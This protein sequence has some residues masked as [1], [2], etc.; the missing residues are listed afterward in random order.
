M[1]EGFE[2][3]NDQD[4]AWLNELELR[5][6]NL[7]NELFDW[8]EARARELA[9]TSYGRDGNRARP[10]TADREC[11]GPSLGGPSLGGHSLGGHS[12][13][14]HSLGEH[15]LGR[16]AWASAAAAGTAV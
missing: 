16:P 1:T 5:A 12:L 11:C 10:G 3:F 6:T 9:E 15:S 4:E 2:N 7:E 8:R 14:G 13:G